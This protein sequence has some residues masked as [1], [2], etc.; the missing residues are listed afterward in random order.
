MFTLVPAL[1]AAAQAEPAQHTITLVTGDQVVV[2][3]GQVAPLPTQGRAG[4]AYHTYEL[5]GHTYVV[6][7]DAASLVASG[8]LDRRLFDITAL[9]EFDYGQTTDIPLLVDNGKAQTS[10][11]RAPKGQAWAS[12]KAGTGKVWLDGKRR[13]D[14][15]ESV[16]QIGAPA[17]WQAGYT[18]KGVTVAVLDTGIDATHP[19]FAGRIA[20]TR[21]FV[22]EKDADDKIGHGTHV[23]STIAGAGSKYRGVAPDATLVVG[24]VC[25]EDG[26]PESAI[27]AGMEWAAREKHAQVINL[28][29]GGPNTEDVDPLEA[30]IDKLTAE[31][32]ALFVVAAGNQ[33]FKP[34]SVSSPST[35]D[36][37][38]SV[39]AVDKKDNEEAYSNPGPRFSDGAIKPEIAAPGTSI[40]AARAT[41]SDLPKVDGIYARLSGTSM[42]T[43]HVAGAAALLAQRQPAWHATELKSVLVSAAKPTAKGDVFAEGA[44]RVDVARAIKQDVFATNTVNLGLQRWPHEDDQ[45]VDGTI[46]YRNAGSAPVTLSLSVTG[47]AFSAKQNEITVPANGEAT[48]TVTADTRTGPDG[49]LTTR[50]VATSG[51]LKLVTPVTVNKEVESYDLKVTQIG[52][53]GKPSPIVATMVLGMDSLASD[54]PYDTDGTVTLRRPKGKYIVDG[55][56]PAKD[57]LS[58]I[59]QPLL[60]LDHDTTVVLDAREAK[61]IKPTVKGAGGEYA[62]QDVGLVRFWDT[63]AGQ[64]GFLS[65]IQEFG[66][67][68]PAS[69][70]HTAQIGPPIPENDLRAW[71]NVK[72]ADPGAK[73][74]FV[75]SPYVYHLFWGFTGTYPNGFAP[76][77]E[78]SDFAAVRQHYDATSAGKYGIVW[79]FGSTAEVQRR[80]G[81]PLTVT[82]PFERTEYYQAQ[83]RTWLQSFGQAVKPLSFPD[84]SN[85]EENTPQVLAAGS[86]SVRHWN[87]GVF[88]PSFAPAGSPEQYSAVRLDDKIIIHAPGYSDGSIDRLGYPLATKSSRIALYRNGQLVADRKDLFDDIFAGQPAEQAT[89]RAEVDLTLDDTKLPL[90]SFTHTA[91]TFTSAQAPERQALPLMT[92]RISPNL[93]GQNSAKADNLFVIPV[94]LQRNPGSTPSKVSEVTVESSF[95]DG[96]TW[97]DVPVFAGDEIWYGLETNSAAPGFASLRVTA[98]DEA[99]NK[100]EQTFVHAYRIGH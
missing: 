74:Q 90:S 24:K 89:Y 8:R 21:S 62:L 94:R 2:N 59:T 81:V 79:S 1:P 26:C 23:A 39:G 61:P 45:P 80:V 42:A 68:A 57:S 7:M 75:D 5:A 46:T 100:V 71:V 51:D 82:L 85:V 12:I 30:A 58:H 15:A 19:D 64:A 76:V 65:G 77:V 86:T 60:V 22:S 54:T 18:G 66:F 27:L 72:V 49:R 36:A 50:V 40:V 29:L 32:G 43:P 99:G 14:L 67:D 11:V 87:R 4:I 78:Q 52:R 97:R 88:G 55:L 44:G 63:P 20:D 37:A 92:V 10:A 47:S 69:A 13:I 16:P 38:L 96:V 98:T 70:F 3:G 17:A 35:A 25:E 84:L 34:E 41:H 33:A 6:P 53:D 83:G 73:H 95:D 31:T 56:V 93:D 48:A 91:W 28:S 9:Q